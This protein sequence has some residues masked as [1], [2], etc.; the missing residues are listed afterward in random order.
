[1]VEVGSAARSGA[2]LMVQLMIE[3]PVFWFGSV[4]PWAVIAFFCFAI[5]FLAYILQF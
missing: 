4:L 3:I 1:M 5:G 2:A